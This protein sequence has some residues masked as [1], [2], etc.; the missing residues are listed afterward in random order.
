MVSNAVLSFQDPW[1]NQRIGFVSLAPDEL[2]AMSAATVPDMIRLAIRHFA[3]VADVAAIEADHDAPLRNGQ[4][5]P[6]GRAAIVL[7]GARPSTRQLASPTLIDPALTFRLLCFPIGS[8]EQD[9][10]I[11][12]GECCYVGLRYH[13]TRRH[14]C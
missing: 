3:P 9:S 7:A 2:A 10:T 8:N 1:E 6:V 11:A 4:L 5:R 13:N 14:H 12:K